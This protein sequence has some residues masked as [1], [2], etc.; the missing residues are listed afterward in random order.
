LAYE[1]RENKDGTKTKDTAQHPRTL[2][3]VERDC[4]PGLVDVL[5]EEG[6]E[7]VRCFL[8]DMTGWHGDYDPCVWRDRAI[9]EQKRIGWEM[10]VGMDEILCAVL[11]EARERQLEEK[12]DALGDGPERFYRSYLDD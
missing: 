3:E 2:E 7:A 1:G 10:W 12:M 11:R 8:W 6:L 4:L 5:R 9:E